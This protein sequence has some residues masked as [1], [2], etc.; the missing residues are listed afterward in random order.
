MLSNIC[1]SLSAVIFKNIF[2]KPKKPKPTS[3]FNAGK[4]SSLRSFAKLNHP[5]HGMSL[6]QIS[7]LE[8]G[9]L[10][11]WLFSVSRDLTSYFIVVFFLNKSLNPVPCCPVSLLITAK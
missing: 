3:C 9:F 2:K 7:V 10:E 1:R 11:A 8:L 4:F 6:V 5:L